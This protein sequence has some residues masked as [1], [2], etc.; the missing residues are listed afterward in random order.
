MNTEKLKAK[1]KYGNI[2][3]FI[4][5]TYGRVDCSY[6]NLTE[7]THI[8]DTVIT[9]NCT[10]N[11]LTSLPELNNITYLKCSNNKLT[12][13]PELPNLTS[14]DCSYNKLTALPEMPKLE[15][16][17]CTKNK[18]GLKKTITINNYKE[19]IK[20]TIDNVQIIEF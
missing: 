9:L 5:S 8:P 20:R 10:G 15:S 13:L 2:K 16:L 12:K 4:V 17:D 3:E 18:F 14:L 19:T 7:I 1:T 11:Y 6:E